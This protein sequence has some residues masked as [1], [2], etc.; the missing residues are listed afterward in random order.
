[1]LYILNRLTGVFAQGGVSDRL[2]ASGDAAA[3]ATN[4][5]THELLYPS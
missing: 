5:L 4:I 1:V 3:T 2:V